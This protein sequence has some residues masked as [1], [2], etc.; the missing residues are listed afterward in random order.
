VVDS[1]GASRR[2]PLA[3]HLELQAGRRGACAR[4]ELHER[5]GDTVALVEVGGWLERTALG[6]LTHALDGLARHGVSRLLLDCSQLRHIDLRLAA[7]LVASL[8]RFGPRHGGVALCGLPAHLGPGLRAV[9]SERGWHCE[10][11]AAD[12]LVAPRPLEARREWAS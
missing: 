9:G 11:S 2:V 7:P 3:I 5:A 10:P 4:V 12:L 6:R 1:N 8:D